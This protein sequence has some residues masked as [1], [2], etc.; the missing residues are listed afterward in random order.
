MRV[1]DLVCY[2]RVCVEF[3]KSYSYTVL[4]PDG[5][6]TVYKSKGLTFNFRADVL[7]NFESPKSL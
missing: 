3:P 5:L 6:V 7:V 2:N 4:T 1:S